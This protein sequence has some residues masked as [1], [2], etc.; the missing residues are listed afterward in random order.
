MD[1]PKENQKKNTKKNWLTL[2]GFVTLIW[3]FGAVVGPWVEK[4]SSTLTQIV[5]VIEEQNID[6]SAYFYTE[7]N[8][9]YEGEYYLKESIKRSNLEKTQAGGVFFLG[10]IMCLAILSAAFFWLPT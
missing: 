7:I 10:I 4:Q 8:A 9:S 6:S 5:K 1:K 2:A 3:F